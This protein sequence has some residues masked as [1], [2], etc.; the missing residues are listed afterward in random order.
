M[1]DSPSPRPHFRVVGIR[2][3]TEGYDK[4]VKP[5]L[6][7][8]DK[9]QA[10]LVTSSPSHSKIWR[11]RSPPPIKRPPGQYESSEEKTPKRLTVA[12]LLCTIIEMRK[13]YKKLSNQVAEY[14]L[15]LKSL[16]D[17]YEML[18]RGLCSKVSDLAKTVGKNGA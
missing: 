15:E 6:T 5:A 11:H 10:E 2:T 18:R 1:P 16:R 7:P 13:E 9:E 17:D 14:A 12:Q 3:P 4:G 8:K